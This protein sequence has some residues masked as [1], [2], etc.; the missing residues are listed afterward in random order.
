MEQVFCK[1]CRWASKDKYNS[2]ECSH[3]DCSLLSLVTGEQL[4]VACSSCR[5]GACGI[6]AKFFEARSE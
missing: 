5:I 4:L 2:W 1:D 6:N 3:P